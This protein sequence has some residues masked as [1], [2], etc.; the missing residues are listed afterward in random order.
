MQVEFKAGESGS[1]PHQMCTHGGSSNEMDIILMNTLE[2][3]LPQ[4]SGLPDGVHAMAAAQQCL[5]RLCMLG[6]LAVALSSA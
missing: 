4:G 1:R 3:I 2:D 5:A 6:A